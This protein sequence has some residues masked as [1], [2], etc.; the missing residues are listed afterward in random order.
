MSMMDFSLANQQ[1]QSTLALLSY[2]RM[3]IPLAWLQCHVVG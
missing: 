2:F 3:W 1:K